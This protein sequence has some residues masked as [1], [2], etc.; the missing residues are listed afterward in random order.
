[1]DLPQLPLQECF[2]VQTMLQALGSLN[3]AGQGLTPQ[4]IVE[5]VPHVPQRP[6][7]HHHHWRQGH[8]NR[9]HH[10]YQEHPAKLDMSH[11]RLHGSQCCMLQQELTF[12]PM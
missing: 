10:H 5:E 8:Q 1:M 3:L 6:P 2:L 12:F 4:K 9:S 7:F 11:T